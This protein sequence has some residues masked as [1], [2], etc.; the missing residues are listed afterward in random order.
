M[1]SPARAHGSAAAQA[2]PQPRLD[3]PGEDARPGTLREETRVL[4]RPIRPW[5][6][7]RLLDA[8]ERLS[9]TSRYRRFLAPV[10]VLSEEQLRYFSEPDFVDH[11]AWVAELPELPGRPLAGVGRWIRSRTD[12]QIAEIALTVVDAYQHQG[13][14]TRLLRLLA[15]S[16]ARR[17]VR[18]FEAWVLYDNQPMR[19]ILRAFGPASVRLEGNVLL[20]HLPIPSTCPGAGRPGRVGPSP[21]HRRQW[22]ARSSPASLQGGSPVVGMSASG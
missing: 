20:F 8:F 22:A 18:T 9:P 3:G 6:K 7:A 15:D 16:A 19:A 11:V 4:F 12:P 5:D 14:G 10:Q 13:L 2:P 1:S 21:G 17:G